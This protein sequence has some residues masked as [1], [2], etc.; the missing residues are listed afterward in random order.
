M[1]EKHWNYRLSVETVDGEETWGIRE[2]YYDQEGVVVNWSKDPQ[3]PTGSTPEEWFNEIARMWSVS[4]LSTVWDVNAE[5]WVD[6]D[7]KPMSTPG[8][9]GDTET[10]ESSNGNDH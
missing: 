5:R 7:R 4:L 9:L 2:I 8:S 6:K 10:K 3:T 1:A